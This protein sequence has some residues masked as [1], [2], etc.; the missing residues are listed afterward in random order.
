VTVRI[1]DRWFETKRVDDTVTMLW[2]PHLHPVWQSNIWHVRGRDRDL[3]IDTGMGIGDLASALRELVD[4]PLTVVATHRHADHIGGLHQFEIRLGHPLDSAEIGNPGPS[5]SLITSD[6]PPEFVNMMVEA[7]T[8]PGPELIDAYPHED[9]DP[10]DYRIAPAPLTATVDEGDII[11]TGDRAFVVLHLPG[12]SPGSIGLWEEATGTL[13][14]GDAIY[15][16]PL[17]DFL[18]ES[19]IE[20]YI[21]TIRR[22]RELPV[23]VVHGGHNDSFGRERLI[24]VADEYLASREARTNVKT[25]TA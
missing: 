4:K 17:Y 2:E 24:A 7:G 20:D 11:D 25:T 13:F 8:P 15:D 22:L 10:H 5:G 3:L 19:S 23:T 18:P 16:G 6:F 12:H 21:R 9:Y 14:S 1:A